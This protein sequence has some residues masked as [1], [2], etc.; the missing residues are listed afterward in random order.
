MKKSIAHIYVYG[1]IKREYGSSLISPN[2]IYPIIK[3]YIRL[4]RKYQHKFLWEL[5]EIGLLKK[6]GRDNLKV[7]PLNHSSPID[8]HGNPLWNFLSLF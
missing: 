2:Q 7:L 6:V 3:W 4:P 5:V 1:L 8:S